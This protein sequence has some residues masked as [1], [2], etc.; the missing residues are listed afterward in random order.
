MALL[1]AIAWV[2]TRLWPQGTCAL[3]W[4]GVIAAALAVA[5]LVLNIAPKS[6]FRRA[7]TTVN[8]LRPYAAATLVRSGLYRW[9]RNPMY[10]GHAVILLAWAVQL[11]HVAAF[12]AVPAYVLYV[13]RFQI[14]AEERALLA[15]FGSEYVEYCRR[16]RRWL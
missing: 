15:R 2:A 7:G 11:R 3:P 16:V 1:G 13:G 8:P 4:H 12:L 6:R 9:S 14:R 10:L 5:G